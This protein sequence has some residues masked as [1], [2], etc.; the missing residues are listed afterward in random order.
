MFS[1]QEL[2][3]LQTMVNVYAAQATIA[4][5][6]QVM[7]YKHTD[8]NLEYVKKIYAVTGN[9]PDKILIEGDEIHIWKGTL[10]AYMQ[11]KIE[12]LRNTNIF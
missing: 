2:K 1:V 6:D 7:R 3:D 5:G 4:N 10:A 12:H 8:E 9:N 11:K